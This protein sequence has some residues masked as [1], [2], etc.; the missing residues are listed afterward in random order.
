MKQKKKTALFVA[1]AVVIVIIVVY[2]SFFYPPPSSMKLTGTM[3]GIEKGKRDIGKQFT[4]NEIIIENPEI[5]NIIQGAEFQNLIKDENFRKAVLSS[6][7]QVMV[8]LMSDFQRWVVFSQ[9]FQKIVPVLNTPEEFTNFIQS[10]EFK[11]FLSQDFQNVVFAIPEDK[12]NLA[13]SQEY[14]QKDFFNI[15]IIT[16]ISSP[17]FGFSP[18]FEKI[19]KS[20]A[21]QES[22]KDTD[23]AHPQLTA[24]NVSF[25]PEEQLKV[26]YMISDDNIEA[27]KA[28]YS[29]ENFGAVLFSEDFISIIRASDFQHIFR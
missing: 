24:I 25:I 9:D 6:D 22:I 15:F 29:D 20:E 3:A 26:V 13:L 28:I 18:N 16:A 17:D 5:N 12:L 19:Y 27:I 1:L 4:I 21:F 14:N 10:D 7:F 11:K 2:F 23:F 8:T